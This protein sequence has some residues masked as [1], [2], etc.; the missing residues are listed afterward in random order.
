M[1]SL[2][3]TKPPLL[4]LCLVLLAP[5]GTPADDVAAQ[6]TR[7]I[8][9]LRSADWAERQAAEDALR[10]LGE[11]S[12]E[13]LLPF[14]EDTDPEV[15]ARVGA[16]LRGNGGW[17]RS[18]SLVRVVLDEQIGRLE[19]GLGGAGGHGFALLQEL[20]HG[21][22]PLRR[23]MFMFDR[24]D[25]DGRPDPSQVYHQLQEML[26][27]APPELARTLAE[28]IRAAPTPLRGVLATL[29]PLADS[30][31]PIASLRD[32]ISFWADDPDSL[33]F[34][35]VA[36]SRSGRDAAF[37]TL[38]EIYAATSAEAPPF[39]LTSPWGPAET[40]PRRAFL[41]QCMRRSKT[42][43]A[44]TF[45]S[46]AWDHDDPWMR[47]GTAARHLRDGGR[48]HGY[49]PMLDPEAQAA[50][51]AAIRADLSGSADPWTVPACYVRLS[52]PEE[53]LRTLRDPALWR[54]NE[55]ALAQL[56]ALAQMGIGIGLPMAAGASGCEDPSWILRD[57][58]QILMG[59]GEIEVAV[60]MNI[61]SFADWMIR[62]QE[63][64]LR[65]R[66][67]AL[68]GDAAEPQ[69]PEPPF[70]TCRVVGLVHAGSAGESMR[71]LVEE[72]RFGRAGAELRT[73]A[74]RSYLMIPR[75]AGETGSPPETYAAWTGEGLLLAY[76]EADIKAWLEAPPASVQEFLTRHGSE[77]CLPPPGPFELSVWT[78][79]D[80]GSA[81]F[82]TY[83][84][85][86]AGEQAVPAYFAFDAVFGW[87][88]LREC[89]YRV[90]I[91][92]GRLGIEAALGVD[93]GHP[94][95]P[96]LRCD[97]APSMYA[98]AAFPEAIFSGVARIA[99]P[100]PAWRAM[101]GSLERH[102]GAIGDAAMVASVVA[103]I[104]SEVSIDL[105][106]ATLQ[107][108]LNALGG[109]VFATLLMDPPV[110]PGGLLD[111]TQFITLQTNSSEIALSIAEKIAGK[112]EHV[113]SDLDGRG[114]VIRGADE[115]FAALGTAFVGGEGKADPTAP[116]DTATPCLPESFLDRL[117]APP[118]DSPLLPGNG[119]LPGGGTNAVF[120][121]N[122][123]ETLRQSGESIPPSWLARTGLAENP[124]VRG[125]VLLEPEAIRFRAQLDAPFSRIAPG[126][127]A[128]LASQIGTA[129]RGENLPYLT[130]EERAEAEAA[131][132]LAWPNEIAA[133]KALQSLVVA[134]VE[135]KRSG[136]TYANLAGLVDPTGRHRVPMLGD[137]DDHGYTFTE[138]EAATA[139]SYSFSAVP[140][141]DGRDG[142]QTFIVNEEGT[143]W[144]KDTDAVAPGAWPVDPAAAGWTEAR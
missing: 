119:F 57:L 4:A 18:R 82:F 63:A 90:G 105:P 39:T 64:M 98:E 116:H 73:H 138:I 33:P 41:A 43:A 78:H 74:G 35:Y 134:E 113:R 75:S 1:R 120:A 115:F 68:R 14:A 53:A 96:L 47:L 91:L 101:R 28:R 131:G 49:N 103:K 135:H 30:D 62:K 136:N 88:R 66:L 46:D 123:T 77:A 72:T 127:A 89:S 124:Y 24:E 143:I 87:H 15:A 128:I 114:T 132:T 32:L 42:P 129:M 76:S 84:S 86:A 70:D 104:D 36:L 65:S 12:I 3:S 21:N 56:S 67:G 55:P 25:D 81:M 121:W 139:E 59:A 19:Q 79:A 99:P 108:F 122:L 20:L 126:C 69:E 27:G 34:A 140:N 7:E 9:K 109:E 22:A 23:M 11:A 37:G 85:W 80:F 58:P 125:Y 110:G 107:E 71:Q 97:P 141:Q 61:R 38:R 8:E 44:V 111:P 45:F 40:F 31:E 54:G 93:P 130:A 26:Q 106:F 51:I 94:I 142:R 2:R 112:I 50:R 48:L 60:A 133:I 118:G 6:I 10:A 100:G 16:I 29:L 137:G 83:A 92:D 52:S 5:T 13:G 117:S 95:Y 144:K 17:R 102:F